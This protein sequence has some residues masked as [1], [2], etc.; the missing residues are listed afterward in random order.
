MT[1]AR[2]KSEWSIHQ[3]ANAAGTTS[4]ALRHYD[5]RGLLK[6]SRVGSNGYRYYDQEA[7]VRLQRILLL[8]DRGLGLD[9]IAEMLDGEAD[10]RTALRAHLCWLK[11]GQAHLARPIASLSRTFDALENE[12]PIM[13]NE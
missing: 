13:A 9:A 3:I 6:P 7:L 12:E 8:H 5:E 1:V 2:A 10:S 4:R 11:A